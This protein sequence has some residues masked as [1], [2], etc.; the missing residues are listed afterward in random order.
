[1]IEQKLK[2][3]ERPIPPK[4]PVLVKGSDGYPSDFS[5][6]VVG[7]LTFCLTMWLQ[8]VKQNVSKNAMFQNPKD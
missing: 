1:M 3:I 2:K 6:N 8:A 7:E 5:G 4:T